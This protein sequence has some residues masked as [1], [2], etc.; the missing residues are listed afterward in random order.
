VWIKYPDK[1]NFV[2]DEQS[3][4]ELLSQSDGDDSVTIYLECEKAI[5]HLPQSK[6]I[7]VESDLIRKLKEKYGDHNVQVVEKSIEKARKMH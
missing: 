4:Y 2:K 5:K 7:N 3:L 6:N 1:E